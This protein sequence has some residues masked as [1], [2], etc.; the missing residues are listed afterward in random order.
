VAANPQL[1]YHFLVHNEN[2]SMWMR[3]FWNNHIENE[4]SGQYMYQTRGQTYWMF[5]LKTS[6]LDINH[7]TNVNIRPSILIRSMHFVFPFCTNWAGYIVIPISKKTW[8]NEAMVLSD[9]SSFR[10]LRVWFSSKFT[11]LSTLWDF[12]NIKFTLRNFIMRPKSS[13]L[14]RGMAEFIFPNATFIDHDDEKCL[15]CKLNPIVNSKLGNIERFAG[16]NSY[17]FELPT[18]ELIQH[19]SETLIKTHEDKYTFLSCGET[20]KEEPDFL[21]LLLP[22]SKTTWA[23]IFITIFGWPLVL[24]LIENDF[25]LNNV[26]KDF[27]ALFIGW[28]M[29]LEQSHLRATNYKGRGPLYCYCG[30][31]LL[32]ILIISNAYK[33]DN[34]KTLT[35]SF[36]LVPLTHMSQ[37]INAGYKT[38]STK[39]CPLSELEI[40]SSMHSRIARE[41]T[42][43]E[44]CY[45]EFDFLND[46]RKQ[47]N[48]ETDE[49]LKLWK[50]MT[51][52]FKE[53]D[54]VLD[55]LIKCKNH[56][57]LAWR[58]VLEPLEK[59]LLIKHEK[60][61]VYLG[62][63]FIFPQRTGWKL[64][65][66]GSVKVLKRMWTI[67]ESGVYNKLLNISYKPPA[68]VHYEPRRVKINGNIFVQFVYHSF[69]LSFALLV[70]IA[71]FH[72]RIH[73]CF[74]PVLVIFSFLIRNF[75]QQTQ[76]AV[77]LGIKIFVPKRN[78]FSDD[79][80]D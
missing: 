19:N 2:A 4:K 16:K 34:I 12:F 66:Y 32:A 63:E 29:I 56:A 52:T 58:S 62:Q 53:E 27:D 11:E 48:D 61:K 49:K 70:F 30:C 79:R 50:P 9:F 72:K 76:N 77:L 7:I 18:L 24:S 41:F 78:Y 3:N 44:Y 73:L 65:R 39:Y 80:L 17:N 28:A 14:D 25:N 6:N 38:Y 10:S 1:T 43:D 13:L 46:S 71:E 5:H 42:R 8:E 40:E 45:I 75:L 23:L 35:K 33:G 37:L 51:Y 22:F 67:V 57:L 20:Y 69:G 59:Q 47:Y 55:L 64:S 54:G 15:C 36:E 60:A 74:T 26:L 68:A 21:A 31:V